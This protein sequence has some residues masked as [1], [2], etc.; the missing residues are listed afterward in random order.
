MIMRTIRF[1]LLVAGAVLLSSCGIY[2]KYE[3]PEM[4]FTD[5]LYRRLPE[6]KDTVSLA[7][8]SWEDF[9]TDPV[10][11][12]WIDLGLKHN[13]YLNVARFKV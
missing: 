2:K 1:I 7:Q 11:K 13:T 9:F 6:A 4:A 5:S 8:M 10:L 3:R 12:E